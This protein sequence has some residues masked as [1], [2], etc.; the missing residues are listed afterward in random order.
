MPHRSIRTMNTE[1]KSTLHRRRRECERAAEQKIR[2]ACILDLLMT[3]IGS[4]GSRLI[5]S[6]QSIHCGCRT[7]RR[8]VVEPKWIH[9]PQHFFHSLIPLQS[10]LSFFVGCLRLIQSICFA[11][12]IVFSL[13]HRLLLPFFAIFFF[14]PF[15]FLLHLFLFAFSTSPAH[16]WYSFRSFFFFCLFSFRSSIL[17]HRFV[18][19]KYLCIHAD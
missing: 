12:S 10:I 16:L 7:V 3:F 6:F 17:F 1:K 4:T 15:P 14:C 18:C 5:R 13:H 2:H 19:C 9:T 8:S 11:L